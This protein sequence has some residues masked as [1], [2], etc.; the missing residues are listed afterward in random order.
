MRREPASE[1]AS[2]RVVPLGKPLVKIRTERALA[3]T[4]KN[5]TIDFDSFELYSLDGRNLPV[6]LGAT[7]H[8]TCTE[9]RRDPYRG[10]CQYV[11]ENLYVVQSARESLVLENWK[12]IEN[13]GRPRVS[14]I[15]YDL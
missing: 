11:D 15:L 2:E 8:A 14:S 3:R 9:P 13:C 4:R 6:S 5:I 1:R 10:L 12:V 7:L